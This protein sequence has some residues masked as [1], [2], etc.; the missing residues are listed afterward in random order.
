MK[1]IQNYTFSLVNTNIIGK[2]SSSL[3]YLGENIK[4]KEK[5]AIKVINLA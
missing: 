4:T 1:K 2:G 3:V 5:V